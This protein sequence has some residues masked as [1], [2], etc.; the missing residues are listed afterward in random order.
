MRQLALVVGLGA[1]LLLAARPGH[2]Q[3]QYTDATGA[4]RVAQYKLYVPASSRDAAVWIGPTGVG[5]PGL[6]EA[7]REAKRREEAYRRIGEAQLQRL[8]NPCAAPF[9][10]VAPGPCRQN[11]Q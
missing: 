9:H 1:G 4:P 7:Q 3:W 6:S 2:A 5:K 8:G 11:A 10:A